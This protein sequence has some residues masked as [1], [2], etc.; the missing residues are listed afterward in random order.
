MAT[1]PTHLSF[2]VFVIVPTNPTRVLSLPLPHS[3]KTQKAKTASK[4]QNK[5]DPDEKTASI[6]KNM[7]DPDRKQGIK[8]KPIRNSTN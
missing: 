3:P 8:P 7:K 2:F 5:K 1:N 4:S 6:S